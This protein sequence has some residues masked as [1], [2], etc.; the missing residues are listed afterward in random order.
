MKIIIVEDEALVA[1]RLERLT[2]QALQD[3]K[4]R[5]TLKSTL[6]DAA[7]YLYEHPVDVLLLDLNL[8]GRDGFDLLKMAV[9][10]SFHTIVVS[11]NTDRALQAY[12][13]GVVDFVPKPFGIERLRRA[14]DRCRSAGERS[15]H[16]TKYLAVRK[17]E[18][19]KLVDVQDVR[20]IRGAGVYS[21]LHLTNGGVELHDKTLS[22]LSDLLPAN[23]L[24]VHKSF[25]ANLDHV[26]HFRSHG[27]SKYDLVLENDEV[28]PVSRSKYKELKVALA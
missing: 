20:Y 2:R 13:Y 12:D 24:R 28:L 7:T 5:I 25:I 10:G 3:D 4:H 16:S 21:E 15:P 14:L 19:L 18:R 11:A 17:A 8:N 1:R 9:S 22:R 23:F 6:E 26:Q 27:S